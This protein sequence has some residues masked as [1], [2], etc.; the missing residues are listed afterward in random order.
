[1]L[2]KLN[3]RLVHHGISRNSTFLLG[4][5]KVHGILSLEQS[6]VLGAEGCELIAAVSKTACNFQHQ[7][8]AALLRE[9]FCTK[10][11]FIREID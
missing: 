8:Y 6:T 2:F 1:M 10:G 4:F 7:E 3:N 5:W 9:N 11:N